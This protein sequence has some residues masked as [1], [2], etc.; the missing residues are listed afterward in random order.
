MI[1]RSDFPSSIKQGL[2]R[3]AREL[4]RDTPTPN[5][6]IYSYVNASA[7]YPPPVIYKGVL[8]HDRRS[9]TVATSTDQYACALMVA[10]ILA[11][12]RL[13][14][15]S[16]RKQWLQSIRNESEALRWIARHVPEAAQTAA[17]TILRRSPSLRSWKEAVR[18]IPGNSGF[19]TAQASFHHSIA[20]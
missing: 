6:S 15:A 8:I 19:R 3:R 17:L 7:A 11:D 20:E 14:D 13:V 5:G 2:R 1:R 16:A 12:T 9:V 18:Y 4:R 10:A